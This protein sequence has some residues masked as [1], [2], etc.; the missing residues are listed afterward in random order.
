MYKYIVSVSMSVGL[1]ISNVQK[2]HDVS[3]CDNQIFKFE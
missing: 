1:Y 2:Y 3:Y